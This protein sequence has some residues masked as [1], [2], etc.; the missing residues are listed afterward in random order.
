MPT[1]MSI[2]DKL[3]PGFLEKSTVNVILQGATESRNDIG[4]ID[5]AWL[6]KYQFDSI[7]YKKRAKRSTS[8]DIKDIAERN[9]LFSYFVVRFDIS[10]IDGDQNNISLKD[11][12][13]INGKNY[14]IQIISFPSKDHVTADLSLV[15]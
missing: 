10:K 7:F 14:K 13:V 8:Q 11:R 15:Q 5:S 12:F 1:N 3:S 4:E 9:T 2:I 6:N